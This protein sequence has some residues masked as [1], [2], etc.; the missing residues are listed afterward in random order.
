MLRVNPYGMFMFS[1]A[2]DIR[3]RSLFDFVSPDWKE[4]D[5]ADRI[6][7]EFKGK[8]VSLEKIKEFVLA[9]TPYSFKKNAFKILEKAKPPKITQVFGRT[10]DYTYPDNCW[11]TIK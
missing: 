5:L 4:T 7:K 1:D 8:T 2:N 3:Q 11:I 6:Y 10:R 9:Q